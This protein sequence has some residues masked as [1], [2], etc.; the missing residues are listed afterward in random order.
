MVRKVHEWNE[1]AIIEDKL[2]KRDLEALKNKVGYNHVIL[3]EIFPTS[4]RSK[5]RK[6]WIIEA[7][8]NTYAVLID[9]RDYSKSDQRLMGTDLMGIQNLWN[10]I[11]EYNQEWGDGEPLIPNFVIAFQK[12]L[13]YGPKGISHFLL[14]K[15]ETYELKPLTPQQLYDVYVQKFNNSYPFQKE[16]LMRL[17]RLSRG[18]SR[19]YLRYISLC[20]E[21]WMSYDDKP[22][23]I[24]I[25]FTEKAIS[26]EDISKD[27]DLELAALFPK[28]EKMRRKAVKA[29]SYLMSMKEGTNQKELAKALYLNE[30]DV[31]R[32]CDKLEEH[33]Y[34]IRESSK[35][36]KKVRVNI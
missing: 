9:T 18:I 11:V 15:M 10:L 35:G 13:F 34:I 17:A 6:R 12:E 22:S 30:M 20:L 8:V 1:Y 31:S 5:L 21:A 3:E 19:R 32:L 25:S 29:I 36:G 28:S 16:V 26:N 33:G 4:E 24:D 23:S 2:T 7:L 27:M 14:G